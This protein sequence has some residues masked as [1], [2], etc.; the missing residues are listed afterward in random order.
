LGG[1]RVTGVE[2]EIFFKIL[3]DAPNMAIQKETQNGNMVLLFAP[4]IFENTHLLSKNLIHY[5][6]QK[7]NCLEVNNLLYSFYFL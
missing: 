3:N 2:R 4:P 7:Y 5:F 6:S 1:K